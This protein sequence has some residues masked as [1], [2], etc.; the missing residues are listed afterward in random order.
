MVLEWRNLWCLLKLEPEKQSIRQ[1]GPVNGENNEV[2]IDLYAYACLGW[3]CHGNGNA[4]RTCNRFR[5]RTRKL[6]DRP[7]LGC[8]LD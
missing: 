4:K 7:L 5:R 6:L 1:N 2:R 3:A 8:R